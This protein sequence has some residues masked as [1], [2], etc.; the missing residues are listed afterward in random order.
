VTKVQGSQ[1]SEEAADASA[2]GD[3]QKPSKPRAAR[4]M[5]ATKKRPPTGR[6]KGDQSAE[7]EVTAEAF[8]EHIL[9]APLEFTSDQVA[10]LAGVSEETTRILWR[11]M[12]FA[13][14]GGSRAFTKHDVEALRSLTAQI[15]EGRLKLSDAIDIARAIGQSTAR[16]AEW[17]GNAIAR[18]L[19]DRGIIKDIAELQPEEV[20]P[21]MR[22]S[23][24]MKPVMEN[25][26]IYSW[27]R[28]M[29]ASAARGAA[30]A[31]AGP[32]AKTDVMSVGFAD[33]V[34]F[35]RLSRQ[36]A[37]VDLAQ[38]VQ[39]FE[40]VSADIV[41][42]TGARLVKTL[43][44][45]VLFIDKS[46]DVIAETALRLHE[47]HRTSQAF[48]KMRIGLATGSVI[49]RM[50]DVYGTTVNRASRLTAMAKPGST[51]VDSNTF[52]TLEEVRGFS[53][54]GTRPRPARGFGLLRGWSMTREKI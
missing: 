11:A 1:N 21:V 18:T 34:G 51:Y 4:K 38:L 39:T 15:D 41:A 6:P 53:F 25:L 16:L 37:E 10:E 14:V 45:E 7:P 54:R 19:Q 52:E 40:T 20:L 31:Q 42:G 49:L 28:Q 30:V 23:E 36:I 29:A 43:G 32:G 50:G 5:A 8:V 22:E 47:A 17:Q 9:G 3:E 2:S 12:G 24:L 46:P 44:D 26:L 48:P 27:R 13:D 35:T 33:L